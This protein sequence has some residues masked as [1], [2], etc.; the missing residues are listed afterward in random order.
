MTMTDQPTVNFDQF[1][2]D[3]ADF[4]FDD[5]IERYPMNK[6]FT[7]VPMAQDRMIN[8]GQENVF[9]K[10]DEYIQSFQTINEEDYENEFKVPSVIKR[11]STHNKLHDI[12]IDPK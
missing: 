11:S 7:E 12:S 1:S 9:Y 10:H 4:T 5:L 2:K 8:K 3:D 6:R